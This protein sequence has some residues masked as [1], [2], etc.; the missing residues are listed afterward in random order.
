MWLYC[1]VNCL[2]V[3]FVPLNLFCILGWSNIA[4]FTTF[5]NGHI[6]ADQVYF[7]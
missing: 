5:F 3:V 4:L 6:A 1:R 7:L 2:Q